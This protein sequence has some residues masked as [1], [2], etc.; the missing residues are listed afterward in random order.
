[1]PENTPNSERELDDS[2]FQ[3]SP[4]SPPS[5]FFEPENPKPPLLVSAPRDYFLG[6]VFAATKQSRPREVTVG[7][8]RYVIG[9]F[10]PVHPTRIPPALDIRHARA[11]FALLSFRDIGDSSLLVRFSFNDFCKRYAHTNG[12]RYARDIKGILGDLMDTYLKVTDIETGIGHSY[13]LIERVDIEQRPIRRKDAKRALSPQ[14]ELWFNGASLSPEFHSI[15]NRIIEL[16]HLKLDVFTSIRSPLAQ[17]IYLYIPSR[18]VHHDEKRPFEIT[19]TTLLK[20]VSHPVPVHKSK[21]KQLFNQNRTSIL[22]QLDGTETLNGFFRVRLLETKD[23]SDWK[24]Q[25]WVEPQ[26]LPKP[27]SNRNSKV[28]QAFL[29][30]G[31]SSQEFDERLKTTQPLDDYDS[32]LLQRAKIQISGNER[33]FQIGKA[34][35]GTGKFQGLL[36]E[37]KGDALEGLKATK[38]PT[39]RLIFRI[40]EAIKNSGK[41]LDN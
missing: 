16:Q 1:M 41:A 15:L 11:I 23:G 17:A 26:F 32:D 7:S 3:K 14:Q 39:A 18:A 5:D 40:M 21:R 31:R 8:R 29:Q 2:N 9:G 13:R 35:L 33:F 10:H 28:L 12:G 22:S 24:L 36:S 38:T 4:D 6:P 27:S 37:A 34:L 30:S 25:A 19:L 20:Q